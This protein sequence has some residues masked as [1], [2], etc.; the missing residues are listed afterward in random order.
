MGIDR[1]EL[2]AYSE[3]SG[4]VEQPNAPLKLQVEPT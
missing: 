2:P 3:K 1:R 4:Q